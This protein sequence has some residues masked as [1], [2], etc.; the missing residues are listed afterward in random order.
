MESPRAAGAF[1]IRVHIILSMATPTACW[2]LVTWAWKTPRVKGYLLQH[3]PKI[4]PT[5]VVRFQHTL[6]PP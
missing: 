2:A 5:A 1:F 4:Q 3:G 6:P